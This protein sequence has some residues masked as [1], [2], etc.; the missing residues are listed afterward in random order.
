M[1]LEDAKRSSIR[2]AGTYNQ[3]SC[4]GDFPDTLVGLHASRD[5]VQICTTLL[6]P[7]LG[8][9]LVHPAQ[10]SN[11]HSVSASHH[12]TQVQCACNRKVV[13]W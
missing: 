5:V 12:P 10:S 8:L 3:A 7:V 9:G 6:R 11:I 13:K 2:C 1:S 4:S